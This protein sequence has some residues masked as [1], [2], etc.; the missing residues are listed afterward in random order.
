VP[1]DTPSSYEP[2][3]ITVVGNVAELTQIKEVGATDGATFQ[4]LDI[5]SV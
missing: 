5:G 2:P 4:G 1:D 3:E